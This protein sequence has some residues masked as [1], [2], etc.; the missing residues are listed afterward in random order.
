MIEGASHLCKPEPLNLAYWLGVSST[1]ARSRK[2]VPPRDAIALTALFKHFNLHPQAALPSHFHTNRTAAA[3]KI[4]LNP[5]T[6][7]GPQKLLGIQKHIHLLPRV[8]RHGTTI[9]LKN[10][11]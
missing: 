6:L 2:A 1:D 3:S 7:R 9:E 11:L 5:P 4:V 10:H 8:H